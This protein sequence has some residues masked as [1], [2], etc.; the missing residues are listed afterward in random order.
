MK[1]TIENNMNIVQS[2]L[3]GGAYIL[4]QKITRDKLE[5]VLFNKLHGINLQ[6]LINIITNEF[7]ETIAYLALRNGAKTCQKT[8]LLFN[9]HRL[10]T[11][12]SNSKLSILEAL[13]NKE[14]YSGLSRAILFDQKKRMNSGIGKDLLYLVIRLG[15][16]GV[17]YINEFPPHV[18]RDLYKEYYLDSTSRILDPCAGWGGRMI[19]ASVVSNYYDCYEPCS[20][21]YEGLLNLSKFINQIDSY[22][23]ANIYKIPFEDAELESNYYDFALTSPP[24]YDTEVYTSESTNSFN[25]Y[26]TFDKWCNSFYIP[27]IAKTMNALKPG[28]SFIL[29]IGSRNYPLNKV[30]LNNF[31]NEYQINKIKTRLSGTTGLGKSGEGESFYEIT[32]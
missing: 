24:Y 13:S 8:S 10:S 2:N 14:F 5:D 4:K 3:F 15:I 23:K 32:K 12:T 22:F 18:A 19:G 20:E 6:Q 27:L 21:T 26:N 7:D 9:P 29:N 31:S 30:L 16:N 1:N 17:Q 25:R 11:R 28:K